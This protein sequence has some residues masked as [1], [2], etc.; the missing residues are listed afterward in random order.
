MEK[1]KIMDELKK[2][3]GAK[4][5][6]S[7]EIEMFFYFLENLD[8]GKGLEL[9]RIMFCDEFIKKLFGESVQWSFFDTE[10][11]KAILKMK[12]GQENTGIYFSTEIAEMFG[13]SVQAVNKSISHGYI[14]SYKR[15]GR[16]NVVYRD[17]LYDYIKRRKLNIKIKDVKGELNIYV[18]KKNNKWR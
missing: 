4:N 18:D 10:V 1:T 15:N 2:I 7:K 14:K 11:G 13:T 3:P 16:I 17:D 6:S 5:L 12:Y 8:R 9:K